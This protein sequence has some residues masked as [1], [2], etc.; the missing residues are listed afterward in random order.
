MTNPFTVIVNFFTRPSYSQLLQSNHE[1]QERV[2][3][4]I[5]F[6]KDLKEDNNRYFT[7]FLN[8]TEEVERLRA[9]I[10]SKPAAPAV[11]PLP[12]RRDG[13]TNPP[14]GAAQPVPIATKAVDIEALHAKNALEQVRS[15]MPNVSMLPD[16][17]E[18]AEAQRVAALFEDTPIDGKAVLARAAIFSL[19]PESI[20][21]NVSEP[22]PKPI[23]NYRHSDLESFKIPKPKGS[24]AKV[25]AAKK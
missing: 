2:G 8:L 18:S 10:P 19:L 21:K 23:C 9:L 24:R 12:R 14:P 17:S 13:Q 25:S 6:Q 7:N 1:L 5:E 11:Q 15:L 22:Y 3:E 20:Q 16:E 4:L